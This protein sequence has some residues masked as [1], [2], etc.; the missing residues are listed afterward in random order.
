[1]LVNKPPTCV[2][3]DPYLPFQIDAIAISVA[4]IRTMILLLGA[5]ESDA[6]PSVLEW[7]IKFAEQCTTRAVE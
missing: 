5:P 4:D 7:V 6:I 1:M 2:I 3:A